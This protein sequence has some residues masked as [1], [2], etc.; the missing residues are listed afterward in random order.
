[1]DNRW[2]S[3]KSHSTKASNFKKIRS[4]RFYPPFQIIID[5][6]LIFLHLKPLPLLN[7]FL[8]VSCSGL[9]LRMILIAHLHVNN[10]CNNTSHWRITVIGKWCWGNPAI[11]EMDWLGLNTSW[12]QVFTSSKSKYTDVA[13][14]IAGYRIQVREV[15]FLSL[16]FIST[17]SNVSVRLIMIE[18]WKWC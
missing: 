1:M 13:F 16:R 9:T 12:C 8:F 4:K 6:F 11:R 17:F 5:A 10:I 7:W 14:C 3:N 2:N 15:I 18:C